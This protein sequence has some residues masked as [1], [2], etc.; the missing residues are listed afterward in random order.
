M[1][2]NFNVLK[3]FNFLYIML[4]WIVIILWGVDMEIIVSKLER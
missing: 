1:I 4:I 2:S 3:D